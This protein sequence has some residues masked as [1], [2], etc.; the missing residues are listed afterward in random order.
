MCHDVAML[1]S[2]CEAAKL[3][4]NELSSRGI[5]WENVNDTRLFVT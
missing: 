5:E 4:I 1:V 2:I 3:S